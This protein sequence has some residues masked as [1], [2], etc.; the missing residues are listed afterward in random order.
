MPQ[1]MSFVS[2]VTYNTPF[3]NHIKWRYCRF[4]SEYNTAAI[5]AL[6]IAEQWR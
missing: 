6:L 4:N 1:R 3:R 5:S 2:K